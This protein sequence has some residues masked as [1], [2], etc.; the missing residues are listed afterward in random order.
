MA[1]QL[2]GLAKS[3]PD[4]LSTIIKPVPMSEELAN[5]FPLLAVGGDN[6]NNNNESNSSNS[7]SSPPPSQ[8][9]NVEVGIKKISFNV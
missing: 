4:S 2:S 5:K 8:D 7:N 9:N 6:K 3:V 1:K